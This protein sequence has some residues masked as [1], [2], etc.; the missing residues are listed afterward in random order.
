[1]FKEISEYDTAKEFN[2]IKNIWDYKDKWHYATYKAIYNYIN[3][4]FSKVLTSNSKLLNAGSGGNTYNIS[5]EQ[6]HIDIA[7]K[8]ISHLNNCVIGSI[9]NIPFKNDTFDA[10]LCVGSA[11]NYCDSMQSIKEFARILKNNGFLLLEFETSNNIEYIS[12]SSYKR[13]IDVVSTFYQ[14]REEKIY[15]YSLPYIKNMLEV[16]GFS[17]NNIYPIHIFSSIIY[18]IS[19]NSNFSSKFS[20][21]DPVLRKIPF[22]N[23]SFC[24]VIL[25]CQK[26]V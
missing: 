14:N 12:T 26:N 1:L 18:R 15:V 20:Y 23:K 16:L 7:D 13:N 9:C 8:K 3:N 22:L 24:N 21:F 19:K 25:L 6:I 5:I 4:V 17:I 10:C 11:L 2:D